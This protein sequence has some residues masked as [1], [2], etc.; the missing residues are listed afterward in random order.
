MKNK[1][2]PICLQGNYRDI[3]GE[4]CSTSYGM[5]GAERAKASTSQL[6]NMSLP[7][8]LKYTKLCAVQLMLCTKQYGFNSYMELDT[9]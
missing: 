3:L 4:L 2:L 1:I 6:Q 9:G 5:F 8:P 7:P